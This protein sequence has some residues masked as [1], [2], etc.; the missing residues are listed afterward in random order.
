MDTAV[1]LLI[2]VALVCSIILIWTGR[3][4]FPLR[5]GFGN[6]FRRKTQVAMVVAGLLIG[7]AIIS[8]SYVIQTTFDS[9]IKSEVFRTLDYVDEEIYIQAA[10]G[11]HS[12]FNISVFDGLNANLSSMPHVSAMAPRYQ[13]GVTVFDP[14][15]NLFEP[16]GSVIGFDA[17]RDLGLFTKSDGSSWAGS[18]LGPTEVIL[19]QK[20][21]DDVEAQVGDNF[22]VFLS[23]EGNRTSFAMSV[24]AIVQNTGRGAWGGGSDLFMRLDVLQA[25]IHQQYQI[26]LIVVANVGGTRNGYLDS[27]LA[28]R[29]LKDRLPTSSPFTVDPVKSDMIDQATKSM[30]MFGQLFTLLGTFTIIAGILLIV[31]IFVM[32]AEERKGEMGVAR[33]LGMRRRNLVQSYVAE[34]LLYALLSAAVGALVGLLLAGAILWA[35]QAVF[36]TSFL[37]IGGLV[38]T[39]TPND[40]VQAFTIGFLITMA[41]ILLAS[42]RVSKLNIVRAIRDIPEPFRRESTKLQ[43]G[44]GVFMTILGVLGT[45][46]AFTASSPLLQDVGPAL[47][48]IGLSV[49]VMRLVN[50]RIVFTASGLFVIAWI[51]YPDKPINI[52]NAGIDQFIVAG[53]LLVLAGLLIVLFNSDTLL[54]IVTRVARRRTWRPV[55]RTAVAYPMNKKFRTGITLA[56]IALV[57]FTIATMSG[58]EAMV[59]STIETTTLRQS[60]GFDIIAT[61]AV[62]IPNWNA[63]FANS[64]VSADISEVRALSTSGLRFS[65]NPDLSGTLQSTPVFGMPSD[66]TDVPFD[67]QALDSLYPNGQAAWDAIQM[68]HSLGIL[69]GSVAPQQFVSINMRFSASVGDMLYYQ[70]ATNATRQVKIIGILYEPIVNGLFV[71]WDTVRTDFGVN[72]PSLFYFKVASGHDSAAVSHDLE[73]TFLMYG[74]FTFDLRPL[75]KQ[76][77]QAV[78]GVFNLLEAYLALGLIVGIAGLG[79]ITMRNVVDR[80]TETGALRALGFRRSMV[81]RSYLF[82]LSFIALTGILMG[83]IL[84]IAISYDLYLKFF[85]GEGSFI[86]P[87]GTLLLLSTIAFVGALL[88]TASPAIRASRM[89]PAVALRKFE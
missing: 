62:G 54:T 28:V 49:A 5:I 70:D 81:L 27:D 19:N 29:E 4:R 78:T 50:Q 1:T 24:A 40:L 57:M 8:S 55:I 48:A 61:S 39:W 36:P 69:D 34:G 35:F 80:R 37:G 76:I 33:A 77:L 13:S 47:M 68:D 64:S 88:A 9:S 67:F 31:N 87:W 53:L 38:L 26:N 56:S 2:L 82:E 44:I 32:L 66:W 7:T 43:I 52:T 42:W 22:T 63:T 18:G 25:A 6:F 86:I 74:M 23:V 12:P 60:G 89:P 58:I 20:M 17:S 45:V 59:S 65:K 71:G 30:S 3:K 11:G 21:A 84:G 46:M 41:T 83:D 79:V 10:D 75:I 15:S 85:A 72:N 16:T 73:R 51:L 14:R